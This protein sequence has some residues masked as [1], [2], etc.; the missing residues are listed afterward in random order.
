MTVS[1]VTTGATGAG[2]TG[3][4]TSTDLSAVSTHALT[5]MPSASAASVT[6]FLSD[7]GSRTVSCAGRSGWCRTT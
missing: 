7:P 4:P 2:A 3:P 5:L 6:W 1:A